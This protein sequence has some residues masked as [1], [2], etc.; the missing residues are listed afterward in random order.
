ML[1]VFWSNK[2]SFGEHKKLFLK[3]HNQNWP[4]NFELVILT[5]TAP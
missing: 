1:F 2:C 3:H 5:K 4:S